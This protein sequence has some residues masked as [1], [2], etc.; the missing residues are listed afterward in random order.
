MKQGPVKQKIHRQ[1]EN[2]HLEQ[3]VVHPSLF[4]KIYLFGYVV[5]QLWYSGSSMSHVGSFVVASVAAH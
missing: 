5:S 4:L 3:S 1:Q 2:S